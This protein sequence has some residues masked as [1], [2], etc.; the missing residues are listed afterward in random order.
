MLSQI[1][2]PVSCAVCQHFNFLESA[3][4]NLVGSFF[5]GVLILL[6]AKNFYEL[7]KSK[8][9]AQGLLA[10]SYGLIKREID[11]A[12]EACKG[13]IGAPAHELP[14]SGPITQAWET[15]HSMGAFRYFSPKLSEKLVKYYSLL[16]RLNANI[17][18]E[19][20]LYLSKSNPVPDVISPPGIAGNTRALE[21]QVCTELN[22][23]EPQ[24]RAALEAEIAKLRPREG[25]I[26][27]DAYEKMPKPPL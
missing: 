16:F 24:L 25:Q 1:P 10:V 26:F 8:K 4:A 14:A 27:S 9:E 2:T 3:I 6:L 19:Q 17:E 11:A 7:P 21:I 22:A 18:F 23:L 12:S 13:L 20:A 5:A 15:L